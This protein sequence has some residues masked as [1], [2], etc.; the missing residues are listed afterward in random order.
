LEAY[1]TRRSRF[2]RSK[3]MMRR[4]ESD[5]SNPVIGKIVPRTHNIPSSSLL[6]WL[7]DHPH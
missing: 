6:L 2:R 5:E 4:E 1:G 7:F 3:E